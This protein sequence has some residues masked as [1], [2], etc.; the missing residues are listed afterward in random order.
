M[1][2]GNIKDF[3]SGG[4]FLA[5]GALVAVNSLTTM[6]I[7]TARDIG[8][9]YFPLILGIILAGFGALILFRGIARTAETIELPPLRAVAAI[10][11]SILLFALLVFP[12]GFV[13][14]TFLAVVV[15]AMASREST[16][17][18]AVALALGL[19]VFN[20]A[21]FIWALGMPLPLFGQ[22]LTG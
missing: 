18:F 4:I 17:L 19:T 1:A 2:R 6:R 21:V 8:P 5:L 10:F 7:G 16:L 3:G 20:V 14:A 12:A 13:P 11:G 15:A 22:V 9:G